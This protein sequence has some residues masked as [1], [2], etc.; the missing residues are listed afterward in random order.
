MNNEIIYIYKSSEKAKKVRKTFLHKILSLGVSIC[1]DMVSIETLDLN[2]FK[3]WSRLSRQSLDE[4]S[5]GLD[6]ET[7]RLTKYPNFNYSRM[8]FTNNTRNVKI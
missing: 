5:I 6:V 3:N 8:T 4:V 2:T 7:P 1:L